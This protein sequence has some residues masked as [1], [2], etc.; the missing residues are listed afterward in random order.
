MRRRSPPSTR[1]AP[2][3]VLRL[4]PN[5]F[6]VA[7]RTD[8]MNL[9]RPRC[10]VTRWCAVVECGYW[11]R[12]VQTAL[13]YRPFIRPRIS[14]IIPSRSASAL[15]RSVMSA[16]RSYGCGDTGSADLRGFMDVGGATGALVLGG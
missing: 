13:D 7:D 9:K 4:P 15:A 14:D 16:S 11:L 12:P 3:V 5:R 6:P 2:P 1:S 10:I 8:W